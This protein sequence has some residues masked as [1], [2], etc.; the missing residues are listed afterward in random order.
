VDSSGILG[1]LIGALVVAIGW[2]V[3]ARGD[4]AKSKRAA[5]ARFRAAFAKAATR[6]EKRGGE[7]PYSLITRSTIPHDAAIYEYRPF[8]SPSHQG[9]FDAAAVRFR[10]RR[11]ALQ[12]AIMAF[13]EAQASGQPL[14]LDGTAA[15][16]D[17]IRALLDFAGN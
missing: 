3:T 5:A 1:A 10:E 15:L 9:R 17:S 6:L 7:D 14:I 13:A 4:R 8:L 11:A 12:P 16:R 2:W